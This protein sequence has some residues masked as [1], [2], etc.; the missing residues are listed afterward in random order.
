MT[1]EFK[2]EEMQRKSRSERDIGEGNISNRRGDLATA[3]LKRSDQGNS[4]NS[5]YKDKTGKR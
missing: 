3:M 1:K 5:M 2:N 4:Q